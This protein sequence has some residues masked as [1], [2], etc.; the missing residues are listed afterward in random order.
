MIVFNVLNGGE[1]I[2]HAIYTATERPDYARNK[3]TALTVESYV[4]RQ[5]DYWVL[6]HGTLGGAVDERDGRADYLTDPILLGY[7][8]LGI[9]GLAWAA[10][11][12]GYRLPLWLGASFALILPV[13]NANHYGV[14]Y[15]GRYVLP[16]LPMIYA[17]IGV[18]VVDL[19]RAMMSRVERPAARTATTVVLGA[20]VLLLAA[21]SLLSLSSYY[22]RASRAARSISTSRARKRSSRR[23]C[24]SRSCRS[25]RA[26]RRWWRPPTSLPPR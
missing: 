8:A 17:A 2:R 11:R 4:E 16:L 1:S 20:T 3:D 13:F 6:L 19:W 15:D 23:W 9:A 12:H 7:S 22:A 10:L 24:G 5:Q 18:L 26:A 14:E 21:A 25:S